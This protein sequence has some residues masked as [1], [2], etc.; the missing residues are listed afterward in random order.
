MCP[1]PI[2]TTSVSFDLASPP[3]ER[4]WK[5]QQQLL[6]F[7]GSLQARTEGNAREMDGTAS[8]QALNN[9]HIVTV[10]ADSKMAPVGNGWQD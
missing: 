5:H 8:V 6:D 2:L 3:T 7:P 10:Q 9:R 1:A 4:E